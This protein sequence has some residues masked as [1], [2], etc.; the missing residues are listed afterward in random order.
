M[1]TEDVL[2]RFN[3]AFLTH[4]PDLL[5]E[6]IAPGCR[7][8]R[9]EPTADGLVVEGREACLAVWQA[10]AANR[11]ARFALEDV[12][13]MGELGLIFWEY[14]SGPAQ[15]QVSRGLNVMRVRGGQVVEGRGYRKGKL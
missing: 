6:L 3:Q 7:I 8:E 13:V 14:R 5:T 15:A 2:N 4:Q 12:V 11:D 1:N 10:Q 9:I